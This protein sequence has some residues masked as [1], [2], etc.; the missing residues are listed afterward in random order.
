MDRNKNL[1]CKIQSVTREH[2]RQEGLYYQ[3]IAFQI[4]PLEPILTS[5]KLQ[6]FSRQIVEKFSSLGPQSVAKCYEYAETKQD[7][8]KLAT[9]YFTEDIAPTEESP[10]TE[11]RISVT[12]YP[13]DPMTENMGIR[14][15]INIGHYECPD[16]CE[17][18]KQCSFAGQWKG[19]IDS[20][21]DFFPLSELRRFRSK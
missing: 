4:A 5:E 8:V 6:S 18:S 15:V 20:F 13:C 2:I 19:P 10:A 21:H 3:S 14:G 7:V 1:I 16:P 17:K 11:R 12:V 9:L